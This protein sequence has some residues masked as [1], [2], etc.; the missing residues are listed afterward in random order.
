MYKHLSSEIR[1]KTFFKEIYSLLDQLKS[2]HDIS[3]VLQKILTHTSD[4]LDIRNSNIYMSSKDR[5]V[6][7][8]SVNENNDIEIKISK[9]ESEKLVSNYFVIDEESLSFYP[10]LLELNS[11]YSRVQILSCLSY[12]NNLLGIM[13]YGH[14]ISSNY[15]TDDKL[16]ISLISNMISKI[17]FYSENYIDISNKPADEVYLKTI[18]DTLSGLYIKSY[19]EQ[20]MT[21]MIKES[22]R[23]KKADSFCL[24]KIE[25]FHEL[26]EKYGQATVNEIINKAGNAIKNFIRNDVDLAGKYTE[27]SFLI[28]LP[29]TQIKGA[30]IFSEKLKSFLKRAKPDNHKDMELFF[31]IGITSIEP[32]DKNKD[33]I[34]NKILDA[35]DFSLKKGGNRVSYHYNNELVEN[36]SDLKKLMECQ[37]I[38]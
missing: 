5:M 36:L 33:S 22:I 14:K 30:I 37:Q 19:T 1:T 38:Y 35:L 21:E 12:D 2:E 24:V 31:S 26:R 20:R 18:V 15:E 4:Y 29:S 32:Q 28:L 11:S 25:M 9:N 8:A 23:Y 17:I 6:S 3:L 10:S 7:I 16:I 27:D 34:F 13:T